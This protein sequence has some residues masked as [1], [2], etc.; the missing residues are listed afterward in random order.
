MCTIKMKPKNRWNNDWISPGVVGS[1]GDV[2]LSIRLKQ[3]TPDLPMRWVGSTVG[4]K[5][6][7]LGSNVQDGYKRSYTS[8]GRGASTIEYDWYN[9]IENDYFQDLRAPSKTH[10]EVMGSLPQF[11]WNNLVQTTMNATAGDPNFATTPGEY[12]LKS[13]VPRGQSVPRIIATELGDLNPG[14][15]QTQGKQYQSQPYFTTKFGPAKM[16]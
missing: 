5:E 1:V 14:V 15:K 10:M 13:G 11:S 9:P 3:S 12:G 2:N 4:K 8:G 16:F 7:R 6:S